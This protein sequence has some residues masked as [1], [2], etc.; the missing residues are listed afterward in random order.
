[1]KKII[2]SLLMLFVLFCSELRAQD[3]QFS[4]FY[5]APL[6]LNPAFAGTTEWTRVGLNY[7]NQWPQ[8]NNG[9]F[10]TYSAYV[11]HFIA[12]ANSG[13]GAIITRDEEGIG[14]LSTTSIGLQYA[15]QLPVTQGV[16]VRVGANIGYALREV[17]FGGLLFPDQINRQTGQIDQAVSA[18]IAAIGADAN[19]NYLDLGLGGLLFSDNFWIGVSAMHVNTPSI[20]FLENDNIQLA[21]R[22]SIHGGYKFKLGDKPYVNKLN[23]TREVSFQPTFQ[24]KYQGDFD[25]LDVGMYIN[26]EPLVLGAWYRG[27]PIKALEGQS[28]NE[29]LVLMVG[30][31]DIRGL[32][33]GYSFDYTLSDLG[34]DS[35]GA[36][37]VSISYRIQSK[38]RIPPKNVRQIPCPKI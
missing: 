14:G 32:N 13:I 10:V 6:Y 24:Y 11:D 3:P 34:I 17:N 36:H 30:V 23:N 33:V 7:R 26:Y 20:S 19:T 15:Y 16:T 25:Q 37:E 38:K 5:A 29:S 12:N 28:N 31:L 35:G 21:T 4:Q 9:N 18:E 22:Y 1:M 2:F 8:I 27:L